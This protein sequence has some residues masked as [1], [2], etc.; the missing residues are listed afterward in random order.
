SQGAASRVESRGVFTT[1]LGL[2]GVLLLMVWVNLSGMMLVRGAARERELSI[3]EAVGAS[4]GRLIQYLFF[5]AVWLAAI[6]GGLSVLVLFGLPAAIARSLGTTVPPELDLDVTGVAIAAGLCFAV[7]LVLGLLPAIRLSRPNLIPVLKDEVAGGGGRVSR[8][9]RAAA[10]IQVA[11]AVPFLVIS[12]VMLDR[13]RVAEF[14]FEP[15]GLAAVRINPSA[16][17]HGGNAE[18]SLRG[19]QAT[20]REA[21][22]IVSVTMG[23]G[24]PIDFAQ[25]GVRVSA[26]GGSEF[27]TAH[28]TR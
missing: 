23:D 25:R 11:M 19:L 7:S 2:A 4:R 28:T 1:I 14:G 22:G 10:A 20:L 12:G 6:G 17:S 26:S 24:M 13:V 21:S 5:E 16:A 15:A 27:A 9:H 18:L 8:V 3:R